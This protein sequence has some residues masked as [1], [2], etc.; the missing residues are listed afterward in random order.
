MSSGMSYILQAEEVWNKLSSIP[1]NAQ[2]VAN[3]MTRFVNTYEKRIKECYSGCSGW[4]I[5]TIRNSF[6]HGLAMKQPFS[7]VKNDLYSMV[8][9]LDND[10]FP[11]STFING[12]VSI[13]D[14]SMHRKGQFMTDKD[15]D[16]Y[17]D[18]GSDL[19]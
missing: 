5:N 15:H 14:T 16:L 4:I 11:I 18:L 17:S 2:I 9:I 13:L 12:F 3:D 1:D 10:T 6:A 7:R 8:S 19:C